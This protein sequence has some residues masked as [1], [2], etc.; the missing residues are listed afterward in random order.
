MKLKRLMIFAALAL[1]LAA[2]VGLAACN[3]KD[4]GKAG[5]PHFAIKDAATLVS[6]GHAQLE[7]TGGLGSGAVT[8]TLKSGESVATVTE[9]GYVTLLS[10]G[11]F[12]VRADKAE[13]ND[14]A[15]AAASR[16]FFVYERLLSADMVS[17]PE[18]AVYTGNAITPAVTVTV[19]DT[20][21]TLNTDYTL[22]YTD[23][24]NAGTA[25]VTVTG[26]GIYGGSATKNFTIEKAEVT[27]PAPLTPELTYNG[28]PQKLNIATNPA[29]EIKNNARS[30][31][32][33]QAVTVA[34]K[35]KAN[36]RWQGGAS[37]D[38]S[39]TLKI[40]PKP[41]DGVLITVMGSGLIYSGAAIEPT[42]TVQGLTAADYTVS[43]E[44][45][46]N[47]G[48]AKA[49]VTGKGNYT[50]SAEKSFTIA[51]QSVTEPTDLI[52]L[53]APAF[54]FTGAAIVPALVT[55]LVLDTDYTVA[56]ENN[57][58]EGHETASAV[59]SF[60]GNYEGTVTLNFSICK[61]SPYKTVYLTD[62]EN[63]YCR[64]E[65][66]TYPAAPKVVTHNGRYDFIGLFSDEPTLS[67]GDGVVL[68]RDIE[69][70]NGGVIAGLTG[71]TL[72][73]GGFG[74][75][76][77]DGFNGGDETLLTVHG[78]D[79]NII[80]LN[81]DAN[82]KCRVITAN[83]S[84]L[85]LENVT[86]TGGLNH[87]T[88]YVG[89]GIFLTGQSELE[90]FGSSA[91]INN[92][93]NI[94]HD[95]SYDV[96]YSKDLWVGAS[97]TAVIH[98]GGIGYAFVDAGEAA[99]SDSGLVFSGGAIDTVY[100]E[101]FASLLHGGGALNTLL[102]STVTKGSYISLSSPTGGI[103]YAGG[104]VASVKNA[105]ETLYY[106]SFIEA[107][108]TKQNNTTL[109]L[110]GDV[111]LLARVNLGVINNFTIDGNGFTIRADDDFAATSYHVLSVAGGEVTL[112]NLTLD[113]NNKCRVMVVLNATLRIENVV[114]TGGHY[115][116]DESGDYYAT[117]L[118]VTGTSRF[119]MDGDS[120]LVGNGENIEDN[121][122]YSIRYSKDLWVGSGAVAVISGGSIGYAYTNANA[123]SEPDSGLTIK[124]GTVDCVYVEYD[125][126]RAATLNYESGVILQLLLS[127]T[128]T[129]TYQTIP[130]P[131][132]STYT[133]GEG[134][135]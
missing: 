66:L 73:G 3:D 50:G 106:T 14:Y 34:L 41:F 67:A 90:M 123:Y 45:N 42:V 113:A 38:L 64:Y 40:N 9:S 98:G 100:V 81:I 77:A 117:G 71:I 29:Y 95:A 53:N 103:T 107:I 82:G 122:A 19:G 13:D 111:A 30:D 70:F 28:N 101:L 5:Q 132:F 60:I 25:T 79:L 130:S 4:T 24:T 76:A 1:V 65:N 94:A 74:I 99:Q 56:L 7:T 6:G 12:T 96:L 108:G 134:I 125:A 21:L 27:A 69:L 39:F 131:A 8:F 128:T 44:N 120:A 78:S 124:L 63:D 88:A 118:F 35:D 129:G 18:G 26:F 105:D 109:T 10:C 48:T 83:N 47:A 97:A 85:R 15:A 102:L 57:T 61:Y 51:R 46:I 54:D 62:G 37:D 92:G 68:E 126:L 110:F 16:T 84:T 104:I 93:E 59:I 23:N 112:K 121:A 89:A 2:A 49:I 87:D 32:G 127:T 22:D 135:I 55:D 31:A 116:V 20:L 91:V 119:Y 11:S 114:M 52:A 80:D 75:Y 36:Y 43:Y 86:V 133:G 33:S 17:E 72:N 115:R 58:A